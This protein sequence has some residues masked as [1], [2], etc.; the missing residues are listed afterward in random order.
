LAAVQEMT[1][2]FPV[3]RII[4]RDGLVAYVQARESHRNHLAAML[5]YRG[6]ME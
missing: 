6:L 5:D 1:A 3:A 2:D 4:N